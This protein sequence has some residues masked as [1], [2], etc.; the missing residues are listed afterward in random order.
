MFCAGKEGVGFSLGIFR[1]K[2]LLA[3]VAFSSDEVI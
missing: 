3:L 2:A 1:N